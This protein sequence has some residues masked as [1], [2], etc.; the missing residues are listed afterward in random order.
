MILQGKE[1]LIVNRVT[2]L[3]HLTET[4][5]ESRVQRVIEPLVAAQ[6]QMSEDLANS[7][8]AQYLI[9]LG[10]IRLEPSGLAIANGM[11]R[12]VIPRVLNFQMQTNFMH[13]E[14][15]AWYVGTDGRLGMPKMMRAFQQFFRENS[16]TWLERY[17]YKEAGPHL[18]LQAFLQRIINGGG[19]IDREYGLGRL[20]TDLL[21]QWDYPGGVQRVVIELKV[22]RGT[23]EKTIE[24]GLLQIAEYMD[25]T[26]ADDAHL[27]I[28]DRRA[29]ISWDNKVFE[30]QAAT[31][32]GR[33][34]SIWGM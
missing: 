1:N 4:L 6:G 9:D 22:L 17:E 2:H 12:E 16:E 23:L 5:K 15:T 3:D 29:D 25:R 21:I 27:V 13:L 19:R 34:V 8:D 33:P 18:V 28:F 30:R 24:Q 14:R 31:A 10:L 11:Y 7:D 32:D 26:G 20:R